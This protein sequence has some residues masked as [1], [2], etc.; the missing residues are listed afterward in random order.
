VFA[1][2][3]CFSTTI[4]LIVPFGGLFFLIK[5]YVDKYNLLFVYPVEFES[6][7]NICFI[8]IRFV[9]LSI[10]FFQFI[11][12]NLFLKL[13]NKDIAIYASIIYICIAIV[14]YYGSKKIFSK[15]AEG[16]THE[17]FEVIMNKTRQLLTQD[18]EYGY[19]KLRTPLK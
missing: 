12:S 11:I 8:V 6:N 10:F 15:K 18:E 1:L 3:F 17:I 7:G 2:T 19:T 4:P 5:Y 16:T 14:I 13:A 9:L